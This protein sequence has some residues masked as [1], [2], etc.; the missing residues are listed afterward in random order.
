M[1]QSARAVSPFTPA[2]AVVDGGDYGVWTGYRIPD[3]RADW[4]PLVRGFYEYWISVSP[5]GRLPGR[6]HI[7]PE[8]VP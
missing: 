5:A 1:L 3:D 6:Q 2:V 8:E 7:A 4:H